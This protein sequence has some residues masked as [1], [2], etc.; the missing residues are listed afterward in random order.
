MPTVECEFCG[1]EF[2][3]KPSR[4]AAN[5][6]RFCSRKCA[7]DAA[8][9]RK[10]WSKCPICGKKYKKYRTDVKTCSFECGMQ[11]AKQQKARNGKPA[12]KRSSHSIES[13]NRHTGF[14]L[15][16]DPWAT[17]EIQPDEYGRGLYRQV[18]PVLGF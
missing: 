10:P 5:K 2:H 6:G 8:Q 9:E 12:Q 17:G 18:D 7:S 11:H 3:T 1:K 13:G 4:I 15:E 16:S 14:A